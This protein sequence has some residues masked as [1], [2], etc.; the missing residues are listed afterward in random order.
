MKADYGWVILVVVVAAGLLAWPVL[1][2][3]FNSASDSLT[4]KDQYDNGKAI[5]YDGSVFNMGRKDHSCAACH[6]PDFMPVETTPIDMQDYRQGE[7]SVLSGLKEKYGSSMLSS[8]DRLY[9]AVRQCL[10]GPTR[11]MTGGMRRDQQ[12]ME[13]LLAYLRR[14]YGN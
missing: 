3:L 5:F 8:E 14:E 9:D 1:R 10:V 6:A 7:H 11:M 2:P 4:N 12:E 13:D